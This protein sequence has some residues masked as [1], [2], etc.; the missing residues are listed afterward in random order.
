MASDE[1]ELEELG[2]AFLDA[3]KIL[4]FQLV[5]KTE[6]LSTT[7]LVF[8]RSQWFDTDPDDDEKYR[9]ALD[10]L[11]ATSGFDIDRSDGEVR[12][13]VP[14]AKSDEWAIGGH[15]MLNFRAFDA[16]NG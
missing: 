15:Y 5:E 3:L 4:T 8:H 11:T 10:P 14:T 2:E 12:L 1:D 9:P 16:P 7:A 13:T 6:G